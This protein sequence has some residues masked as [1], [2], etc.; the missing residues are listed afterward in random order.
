MAIA[1]PPGVSIRLAA[2]ALFLVHPALCESVA[3]VSSRKD[4]L[5]GA[6]VFASL[7]LTARAARHDGVDTIR[8]ELRSV[9]SRYCSGR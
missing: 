2:T 3:W 5:C 1:M 9:A 4:V 8:T 7:W 6:F